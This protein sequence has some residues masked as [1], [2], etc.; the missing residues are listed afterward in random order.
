LDN[1]VAV[2]LPLAVVL[3]LVKFAATASFP[4]QP[5]ELLTIDLKT[6]AGRK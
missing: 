4:P 5:P 6:S 1:D 2:T 3:P